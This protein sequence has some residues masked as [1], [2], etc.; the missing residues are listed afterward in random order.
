[1]TKRISAILAVLCIGSLVGAFP[2]TA[3]TWMPTGAAAIPP[4]GFLGFCVKYLQECRGTSQDNAVIELSQERWRDL[5]A[6]QAK[7]NSQIV[8]RE[9]P[10]HAWEYPTNGYGDCNTFALTKRR[11]LIERGWPRQSL[12]LASATTERGEG[13]LVLIAH[14]TAGDLVLD[15]RVG[16]IVDWSALPYRWVSV[17]SPTSPLRWLTVLAQ[18]INTADA[19]QVMAP[20]ASTTR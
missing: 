1:M 7:V 15:N 3:G 16:P 9:D 18:P 2:A 19:S 12:L 11:E 20:P 4:G 8:P 14:T 5:A 13:H 10:R 6:V 17:Q